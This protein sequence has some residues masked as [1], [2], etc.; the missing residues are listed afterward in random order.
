M[1]SQSPKSSLSNHL[2]NSD[3]RHYLEKFGARVN[4]IGANFA[5]C[6]PEGEL[7][8]LCEGND[9][10]TS[11]QHIARIA[12]QAELEIGEQGEDLVVRFKGP[13]RVL[14]GLLQLPLIDREQH[15]RAVAMIDLGDEGAKQVDSMWQAGLHHGI[16]GQSNYLKEMLA[17]LIECF[18]SVVKA[19]RHTVMVG[20]ELS[21]VYEELVMLHRLNSNMKITESDGNFLQIACDSLTD[22]VNL[23]G[24][25]ILLEKEINGDKKLVV[26]AGSGLI[27]LDEHISSLL[28]GRL[29]E[30]LNTGRE[31]LL[32]SEVFGEFQ[33]DWPESIH[34]ILAV[35]LLGKDNVDTGLRA[36]IDHSP[37]LKGL[38]VAVNS[39]SKKDFDSTDIKLF[40]SVANG[41]AVFIENGRLFSD[42]NDLYLGSLRALTNS[43]DAK[44]CYTHGHSERVAFIA[45]WIAE[46]L[47]A[48]DMIEADQIHVVYLTGLL[49]DIGK[50][51]I[52][53]QVLRKTGPL[54]K[55]ERQAICK[56]PQIGA[57]ILRGIK[58]M[59]EVI[60]GVMCHH[61]RYDGSGYPN[62][63]NND[64]IPLMAR[65][66]GLADSFDAMTSR[67]S[68]RDALSVKQATEEIE[69]NL[70]QQFDPVIGRIFLDSDLSRLWDLLQTGGTD[71]MDSYGMPEAS[72][73]AL[74]ILI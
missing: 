25:A 53:D 27:D 19:E 21:Q 60:P 29:T 38:M 9:F 52:D 70:G 6:S 1:I 33:Y 3:H 66:V 61:E 55:E 5:V 72:Q 68:Y 32:D 71:L 2:I 56:H 74:G 30:Q 11:R 20:T 26:A 36:G 50:I 58:Q 48:Q 51:G 18:E 4:K 63:L 14:A 45:R 73:A 47:V 35:P 39:V 10:K 15:S 49:H 8:L 59:R 69:R 24:I 67:R 46:Q 54:N 64:Q 40:S 12:Q 13:N 7:Y 43:I 22:V 28:W 31:A 23:E 57:G 42:L 41:C 37:Y 44:D 65:I 17:T 16:A 62:H 34:N